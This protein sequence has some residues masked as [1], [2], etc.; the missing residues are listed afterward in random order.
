MNVNLA[1]ALWNQATLPVPNVGLRTH[2]ATHLGL[3]AFLQSINSAAKLILWLLPSLLHSSTQ[4]FYLTKA[5]A[6]REAKTHLNW[7]S[8]VHNNNATKT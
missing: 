2:L 7:P 8:F 3:S 6:A 5:R 1:E 4:L